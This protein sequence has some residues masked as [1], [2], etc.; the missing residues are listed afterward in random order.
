MLPVAVANAGG[1]SFS[2]RQ[3]YARRLRFGIGRAWK[4]TGLDVRRW[5]LEPK[6]VGGNRATTK[7]L[8]FQK[9]PISPL[10]FTALF[11]MVE[12]L[13]DWDC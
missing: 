6:N 5:S 7:D 1:R 8:P 12:L 10:R 9:R 2:W 13:V 11:A 3:K 4:S